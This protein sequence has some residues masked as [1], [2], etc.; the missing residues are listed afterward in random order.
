MTDEPIVK[1]FQAEADRHNTKKTD[2]IGAEEMRKPK[3]CANGG[4]GI[5]ASGGRYEAAS[6]ATTCVRS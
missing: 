6:S 4:H 2:I 5:G 1:P 3:S